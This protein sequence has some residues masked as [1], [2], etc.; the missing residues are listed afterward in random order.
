MAFQDDSPLPCRKPSSS[1]QGTPEPT[2]PRYFRELAPSTQAIPQPVS[3]RYFRTGSVSSISSLDS[4]PEADFLRFVK[5]KSAFVVEKA[6]KAVTD[7][8]IRH[9]SESVPSSPGRTMSSFQCRQVDPASSLYVSDYQPILP[10]TLPT[11]RQASVAPSRDDCAFD[12]YGKLDY[13]DQLLVVLEKKQEDCFES[14]RVDMDNLRKNIQDALEDF[15][16]NIGE[17]ARRQGKSGSGRTGKDEGGVGGIAFGARKVGKARHK[18]IR[19][20]NAARAREVKAQKAESRKN[21][22]K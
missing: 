1:L 6:A 17:R 14:L 5:A 22:H 10:S 9:T 13:I 4:L 2:S 3:S 18:R 16:K 19:A 11:P 20:A 21:T 15:R 8:D 12:I 7:H